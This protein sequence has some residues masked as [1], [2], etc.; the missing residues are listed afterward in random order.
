MSRWRGCQSPSLAV[1]PAGPDYEFAAVLFD[2]CADAIAVLLECR[3]LRDFDV[4][5]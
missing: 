5:E 4:S 1:H 3:R 2:G